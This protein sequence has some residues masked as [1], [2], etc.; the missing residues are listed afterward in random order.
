[1][2]KKRHAAL[3]AAVLLGMSSMGT[4]SAV[5]RFRGAVA[6]TKAST[7]NPKERAKRKRKR[8]MQKASRKA[9]RR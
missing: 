4:G 8:K 5:R 2:D 1:M 6:A 9:A 3:Q 7:L